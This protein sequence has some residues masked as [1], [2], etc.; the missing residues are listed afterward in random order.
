[1]EQTMTPLPPAF[2]IIPAPPYDWEREGDGW[3]EE[4][5]EQ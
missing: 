3:P 4:D 5:E 2:T 1:M